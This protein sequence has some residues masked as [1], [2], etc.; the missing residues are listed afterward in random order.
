MGGGC[1]HHPAR[2]SPVRF[3]PSPAVYFPV[4]Q[5]GY[6]FARK[7]HDFSRV[8]CDGEDFLNPPGCMALFDYRDCRAPGG[9]RPAAR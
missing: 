3:W 1:G 8:Q 4:S 2:G 6:P 9:A 5:L 7:L